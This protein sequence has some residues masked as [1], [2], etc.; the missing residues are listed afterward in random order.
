MRSL[1]WLGVIVYWWHC[2]ELPYVGIVDK[3]IFFFNFTVV[4]IFSPDN[5]LTSIAHLPLGNYVSGAH[6]NVY[7]AFINIFG[8]QNLL[9]ITLR[10]QTRVTKHSWDSSEHRLFSS[11][12]LS[13]YLLLSR[14]IYIFYEH[15][16]S[17][18]FRFWRHYFCFPPSVH[19]TSICR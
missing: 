2:I 3:Q 1:P 12:L 13:L 6:L 17:F 16:Y 5:F 7:L 11:V 9:P 14:A 4:L 8:S 15:L 10:Q 18:N 19:F